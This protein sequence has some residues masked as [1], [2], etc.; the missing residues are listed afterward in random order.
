MNRRRSRCFPRRR[1]VAPGHPDRPRARRRHE[2]ETL[3]RLASRVPDHG[4]LAP[5]RFLVFAG[6]RRASGPGAIA[7]E[8][9]LADNPELDEAGRAGRADAVFALAA[10]RRRGLARRPA[11]QNPGMGAGAV[12]RRRLRWRWR[13]PPM[14]WATPRPGSPNGAPM[15]RDSATAIGLAEHERIAGFVHIGRPKS[16]PE[17]RP[18][19]ALADIVTYF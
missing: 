3:L 6:R 15:T 7:L 9:K 8:I 5:W 16:P 11:R 12:G 4:K 17:D 14:R 18:R 10:R 2:L 19:P 13:S 1:S